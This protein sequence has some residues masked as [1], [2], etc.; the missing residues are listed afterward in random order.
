MHHFFVEKEQISD[1]TVS[2]T[3][4]DVRYMTQV[5]RM[6]KGEQLQISAGDEWEYTCRIREIGAKEILADIEDIQK[7]G[8]EL[9]SRIVLFQCIPKGEKME[10]ILQKAVELGAAE[11]VPVMS[12]R[13]IVR[14]DE[15]KAASRTKRWNA[16]ALSAARQSKR[17]QIPEV[18]PPMSWKD[19][20]AYAAALDVRLMPYECAEGMEG[21]RKLLQGITPGQSIAVLI[22]PEGGFSEKEVSEAESEGF[23]TLTLGGRILRTETAG[24]TMLSILMYLLED[25]AG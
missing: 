13:C 7:A 18:L 5:L 16:V 11:I 17:L 4:P 14:L 3:G 21:T 10:W 1:S 12:E 19:A 8:R 24:M 15:K 20:M 25:D 6:K 22:G 23:Q 2:I 9:P